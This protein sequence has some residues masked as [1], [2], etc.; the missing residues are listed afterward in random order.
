MLTLPVGAIQI[1][2]T[3]WF[4]MADE[5]FAAPPESPTAVYFCTDAALVY[6][7]QLILSPSHSNFSPILPPLP[8][9]TLHLFPLIK[10]LENRIETPAFFADFGPINL[11]LTC[12][13]CKQLAEL[14]AAAQKAS[15]VVLYYARG[16]H[17]QANS[18]VLLCAYQIFVLGLSAERAYAPFFGPGAPCF[19][20]FR[21]AA[22]GLNTFPLFVLDCAMAMAKAQALRH[23][24]YATFSPKEFKVRLMCAVVEVTATRLL[25]VFA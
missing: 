10:N 11:G 24:H 4:Y 3:V 2:S 6:T 8:H 13:F 5:G 20:P 16:P 7:G 22:F 1:T 21:D 14:V 23:F 17:H 15:K 25:N 19:F 12:S 18:A 9:L